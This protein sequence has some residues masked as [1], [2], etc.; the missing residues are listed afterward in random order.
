MQQLE[1]ISSSPRGPMR[2]LRSHAA[3]ARWSVSDS[4]SPSRRSTRRRPTRTSRP[5]VRGRSPRWRAFRRDRRGRGARRPGP[6]ARDRRSDPDGR[7][8]SHGPGSTVGLW[9][10]EALLSSPRT[11]RPAS[12]RNADGETRVT[13]EEGGVRVV[14]PRKVGEPIE[15]A[16]LD[17]SSTVLGGDREARI[18]REKAGAY[19]MLCDWS[20]P[21]PSRAAP[22]V[23][24]RSRVTAVIANP[25]EAMFAAPA[26]PIAS[27]CSAVRRPSPMRG[28]RSTRP[29]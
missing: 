3:L 21:W 26:I 1:S 27:R 17:S 9:H 16:A 6:R 28:P 5:R 11:A 20:S 14:D 24:A 13:L 22:K 4:S 12:I 29:D 18:L 7:E 15:L 19:A 10:D 2:D 23:R 8:C 25:R